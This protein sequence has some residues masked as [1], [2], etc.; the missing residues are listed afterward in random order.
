MNETFKLDTG[1]D[2]DRTLDLMGAWAAAYLPSHRP[3]AQ[4]ATMGFNFVEVKHPGASRFRLL[5]SS[6]ISLSARLTRQ[7]TAAYDYLDRWWCCHNVKVHPL[8]SCQLSADD[9]GEWQELLRVVRVDREDGFPVQLRR[10]NI[11][12]CLQ[13]MFTQSRCRHEHDCCGC[14]SEQV[15]EVTYMHGGLYWIYSTNTVNV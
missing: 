5:D 1:A 10:A 11:K 4:V 14:V 3:V 6:P 2:L 9:G 13:D 7:Y 15:T 12:R 8:L